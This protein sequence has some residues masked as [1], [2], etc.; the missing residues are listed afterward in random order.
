MGGRISA[1]STLL[2]TWSRARFRDFAVVLL[3]LMTIA[4]TAFAV[5]S[6]LAACHPDRLGPDA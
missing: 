4:N 6:A 1:T 2:D 3:A 5:R